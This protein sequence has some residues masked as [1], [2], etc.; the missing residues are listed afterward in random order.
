MKN[1]ILNFNNYV[2]NEY[3]TFSPREEM[4]KFQGGKGKKSVILVPGAGGNSE[5]DFDVLIPDLLPSYKVWTIDFPNE[6]NVREFAKEVK[7]E[8][9]SKEIKDF[10]LAGYSLGAGIVWHVAKKIEEDE[11]MKGNFLNKIFFID[12]GIPKTLEKWIESQREGNPEKVAMATPSDLFIKGR[13][14]G[15]TDE[16]ASRL[17]DFFVND[18]NKLD[19]WKKAH[20]GKYLDYTGDKVVPPSEELEKILSNKPEK[21]YI[22]E[23][24][25]DPIGFEVRYSLIDKRHQEGSY[26]LGFDPRGSSFRKFTREEYDRHFRE[27]SAK[28]IGL[29]MDD[30]TPLTPLEST[31]IISI[32]AGEDR[33]NPRS[34]KSIKNA[35][36]EVKRSTRKK[37][38]EPK[39]V[40]GFGHNNIT[41]SPAVEEYIRKNIVNR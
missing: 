2:L 9:K 14:K 5:Q 26:S 36:D 35:S 24:K 31:E 8:I 22:L 1:R 13:E 18:E 23:D 38:P 39:V 4:I 15:L 28:K 10:A 11:S 19:Q 16:E 32:L 21:E 37:S 34:E 20:K 7:D 3:R 33:G 6:M 27:D 41:R 30:L 40:P 29:G 12:G 17:Q 25:V